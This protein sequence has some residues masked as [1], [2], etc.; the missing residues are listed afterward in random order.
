MEKKSARRGGPS[1]EDRPAAVD[2]EEAL[3]EADAAAD[4][5]KAE[6]DRWG[7]AGKTPTEPRDRFW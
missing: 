1:A 3:R 6:A 5:A 2:A 4:A 7:G